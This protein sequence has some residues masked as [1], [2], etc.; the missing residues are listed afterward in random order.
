MHPTLDPRS[1]RPIDWYP[2]DW[3]LGIEALR[4]YASDD[5]VTEANADYVHRLVDGIAAVQGLKA[6]E[7][8][9]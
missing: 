6:S 9:R 3:T 7:L 1:A 8:L 5:F 2:Q 4:W